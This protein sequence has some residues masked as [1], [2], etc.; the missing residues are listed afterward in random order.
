METTTTAGAGA[1]LTTPM[2]LST[3]NPY[4]QTA[5]VVMGILWLA[6]QMY[7]KFKNERRSK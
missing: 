2:W 4:L 1:M 6:M 7:Y 5:G 3:I